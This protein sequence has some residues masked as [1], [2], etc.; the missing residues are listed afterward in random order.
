MWSEWDAEISSKGGS[1][2]FSRDSRFNFVFP[3]CALAK[4]GTL[5]GIGRR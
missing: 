2:S 4:N 3:A 5:L 1:F